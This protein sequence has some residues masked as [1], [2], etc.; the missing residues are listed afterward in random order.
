[1]TL[2][3]RFLQIA[4]SNFSISTCRDINWWIHLVS[5]RYDHSLRGCN[6]WGH[7]VLL[8]SFGLVRWLAFWRV[9]LIIVLS[10]ILYF[11]DIV[12]LTA[13]I[14]VRRGYFLLSTRCFVAF[15]RLLSLLKKP[16]W[17]IW[18]LFIRIMHLILAK[19]Y[20]NWSFNV[21]RFQIYCSLTYSLTLTFSNR[22]IFVDN[23]YLT[24]S[25]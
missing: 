10:L 1:M 4:S 20:N 21:E 13:K 19:L 18:N 23:N 22:H 9:H 7:C 16:A 24:L 11:S 12:S 17:G 5:Y 15:L 14:W 8:S 6:Y 25:H 2:V 3:Y